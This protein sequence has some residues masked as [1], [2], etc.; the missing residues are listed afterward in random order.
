MQIYNLLSQQNFLCFFPVAII[1]NRRIPEEISDLPEEAP[2]SPEEASNLSEQVM[3]R[4][5]LIT[6]LFLFFY[7]N[8]NIEIDANM[9]IGFS[10]ELKDEIALLKKNSKPIVGFDHLKPE[11]IQAERELGSGANGK[12]SLVAI[13]KLNG[14]GVEVFAEKQVFQIDIDHNVSSWVGLEGLIKES[15]ILKNINQLNNKNIARYIGSGV[16]NEIP[17]LVIEYYQYG[18]LEELIE[19][20]RKLCSKDI[21]YYMFDIANALSCLKD[22]NLIHQDIK[23]SNILID[24]EKILKLSDFG[25][26]TSLNGLCGDHPTLQNQGTPFIAAPERINSTDYDA[27][28][29]MWSAGLVFLQMALG[30]KISEEIINAMYEKDSELMRNQT[31]LDDLIKNKLQKIKQSRI[32]EKIIEII[33]CCLK[34]DP[35]QRITPKEIMTMFDETIEPNLYEIRENKKLLIS[36]HQAIQNTYTRCIEAVLPQEQILRTKSGL[37]R[38]SCVCTILNTK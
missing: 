8:K 19:D 23:P 30:R 6:N 27:R 35:S 28:S 2:N 10:L 36:R 18:S 33:L 24:S 34:I 38:S 1:P 11:E 12:V 25:E 5:L 29:D 21:V 20:D 37:A 22:I 14:Q 4:S 9:N 3:K 32:R 17:R 13:P 31:L 16:I 15:L 7:K 26:A